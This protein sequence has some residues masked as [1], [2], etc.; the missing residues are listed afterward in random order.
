ME[1]GNATAMSKQC[2][3]YSFQFP[4]MIKKI[5]FMKVQY[6]TKIDTPNFNPILDRDSIG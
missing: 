4:I 6:E 5:S 3:S 2:L 1:V